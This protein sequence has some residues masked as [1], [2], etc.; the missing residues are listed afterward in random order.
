M[1]TDPVQLAIETAPKLTSTQQLRDVFNRV[2]AEDPQRRM[3]GG[4]GYGD[5]RDD[6]DAELIAMRERNDYVDE[7]A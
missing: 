4:P 2:R 3:N 6:E 7:G 5:E 1:R